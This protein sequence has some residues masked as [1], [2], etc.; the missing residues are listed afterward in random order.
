MDSDEEYLSISTDDEAMND[1]SGDEGT[2]GNP[3][4]PVNFCTVR[5]RGMNAETSLSA[6]P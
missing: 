2:F 1:D 4:P 3:S 5:Q 6:I